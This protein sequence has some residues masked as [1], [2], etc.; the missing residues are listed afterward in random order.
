MDH[1]GELTTGVVLDIPSGRCFHSVKGS[2]S[3]LDDEKIH[4]RGYL[5]KEAVFSSFLGPDS[6]YENRKILTWPKRGRY[7]GA[8]SLEICYV[9]KGAL[10]I[11]AMF[12]RIPRITDIAAAYLVLK[13]AGG[14][15][16]KINSDGSWETYIP[17]ENENFRG[18]ISLGD[19]KAMKRIIEIS[20]ETVSTEEGNM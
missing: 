10:D 19:V 16:I 14:E 9:A 13:E 5:E 12:S 6:M 4:T 3:Y 17:G 7:F 11:F 2:G 18:L 1:K 20:S 8:I 15:L